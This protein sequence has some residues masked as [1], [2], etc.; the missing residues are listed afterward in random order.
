MIIIFI[1][2]REFIFIK[3]SELE[4]QV[5]PGPW[6]MDSGLGTR[7][8]GTTGLGMNNNFFAS[9]SVKIGYKP[10]SLYPSFPI[11]TKYLQSIMFFKIIM[12]KFF[13]RRICGSG[14]TS[15]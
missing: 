4:I 2:F 7:D 9:G 15:W 12:N 10:T 1:Y 5:G 8:L 6:T 11:P 3:F 13:R 14:G